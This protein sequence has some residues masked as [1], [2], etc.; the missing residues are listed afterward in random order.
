MPDANRTYAEA[1]V[2]RWAERTIGIPE[3]SVAAVKMAY[4]PARGWSDVTFEDESLELWAFDADGRELK[5]FFV[6]DIAEAMF[7]LID[8]AV[9]IPVPSGG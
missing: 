4:S 2:C 5:W 8:T 1:V 9:G 3:G 7:E 6:P